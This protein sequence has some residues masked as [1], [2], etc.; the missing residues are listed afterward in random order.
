M[1]FFLHGLNSHTR[2]VENAMVCELFAKRGYNVISYDLAGFGRS[3]SDDE[4]GW[5]GDW[6]W[7][8]N[9]TADLI[10]HVLGEK[11][12][13]I[14][15]FYVL[16]VSLGGAIAIQTCL[17][18]HTL[19]ENIL[20]KWRGAGFV[21]PAIEQ[22]LEP[23]A[24]EVK[25]LEWA[26]ALGGDKLAWGP[27]DPIPEDKLQAKLADPYFYSGRMKLGLGFAGRNML[28]D[29]KER[30]KDVSFPYI[31]VHGDADTI[32]PFSGSEQLIAV[33]KTEEDKK[34]LHRIPNSDHFLIDT[35]EQIELLTN[36]LHDWFE[37]M[38]P[39]IQSVQ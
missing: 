4:R 23:S 3:A 30:L 33:S 12:P 14:K 36:I 13:H 9:D 37:K 29:L 27:I 25:A 22:T 38:I 32:C 39:N 21:C 8:V 7:W 26:F 10:I 20:P 5:I 31:V 16:G 15:H 18:L 28:Q 35:V 11:Y 17:Q 6:T 24:V 19:P 34:Y 1:I 2:E